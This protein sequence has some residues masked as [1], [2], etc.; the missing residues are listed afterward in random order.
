MDLKLLNMKHK[1]ASLLQLL[2][3]LIKCNLNL[4]QQAAVAH[5]KQDGVENKSGST[6]KSQNCFQNDGILFLAHK[7]GNYVLSQ[8]YEI[9]ESEQHFLSNRKTDIKNIQEMKVQNGKH[10]FENT[11]SKLTKI[12]REK[13]FASYLIRL[14]RKEIKHHL[15]MRESS[16]EIAGNKL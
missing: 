12:A 7:I 11:K 1:M 13:E 14:R 6:E 15:L 10:Y 2:L 16:N 4:Q 3:C 5:H 9:L 8:W